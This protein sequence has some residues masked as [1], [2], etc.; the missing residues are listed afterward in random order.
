[1]RRRNRINRPACDIVSSVEA[2]MQ[3]SEHIFDTSRCISLCA[4][5]NR[6]A[7]LTMRWRPS[8]C[9][10][11]RQATIVG[12]LHS[13]ARWNGSKGASPHRGQGSDRT[14]KRVP[15]SGSSPLLSRHLSLCLRANTA[16]CSALAPRRM[17]HTTV[18]LCAAIF[19]SD[20]REPWHIGP[21]T[22]IGVYRGCRPKD[23]CGALNPS[24]SAAVASLG[25]QGGRIAAQNLVSSSRMPL[26]NASAVLPVP[27]CPSASE[28]SRR[29]CDAMI[30]QMCRGDR[31]TTCKPLIALSLPTRNP[32]THC[33]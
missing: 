29:I 8:Y 26:K 2:S 5:R 4:V 7:I 22:L 14:I 27:E 16:I 18:S 3:T 10:R 1:M 21:C 20:I 32:I 13:Q 12:L 28:L 15:S 11:R 30:R 31:H 24:K 33:S 25:C 19:D 6:S 23:V 9:A 17:W